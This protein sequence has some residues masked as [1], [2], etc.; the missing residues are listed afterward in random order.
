MPICIIEDRVQW[1]RSWAEALRWLEQFELKHIEFTRCIK[2]FDHFSKIW[3]AISSTEPKLGHR[4]FANKQATMFYDMKTAANTR[5]LRVGYKDF[6]GIDGADFIA[7]VE[8][9]REEEFLWL[10]S[11]A[12]GRSQ[13][14]ADVA[15]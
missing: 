8:K 7:A 3:S 1:H 13:T 10:T 12:E 14:S 4:A 11:L 2:Y 15:A 6:V 5:F 9:F